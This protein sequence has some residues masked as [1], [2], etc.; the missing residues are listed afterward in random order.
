MAWVQVLQMIIYS[1]YSNTIA[2]SGAYKLLPTKKLYAYMV[3]ESSLTLPW[4][5]LSNFC[6]RALGLDCGPV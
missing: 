4:S 6:V 3:T 1:A 5:N 2:F